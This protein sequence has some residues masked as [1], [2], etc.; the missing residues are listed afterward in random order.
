MPYETPMKKALYLLAPLYLSLLL[1]GCNSYHSNYYAPTNMVIPAIYKQHDAMIS[2]AACDLNGVEFQGVYS[3]LKHTALLYNYMNIPQKTYSDGTGGRGQ[4]SEGGL[5]GYYG[6]FPWSFHL[7]G[8]YGRGFAENSYGLPSGGIGNVNSKSRLDFEH[9]F[10]QPGFVLQTRG[11][12]FGMA[13]RQ[14]WLHYYKGSTD[15][16]AVSQDELNILRNIEQQT[17][18]SFGEFGLTL[19]FRIR[20]FT[21]SYNSVNIFDNN[22]RYRDMHF[23]P[24]NRSFM[25]TIDLYEIWRWKDTPPR[26]RKTPRINAPPVND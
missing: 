17:P 4:L 1:N 6:N 11:V 2:V 25:I 15:V 21:F 12:R 19:G 8:G 13:Y 5:S 24:D 18:F 23:K 3:P 9:W 7:M 10:L 20:P 16:Q 22:S 14:V 26:K